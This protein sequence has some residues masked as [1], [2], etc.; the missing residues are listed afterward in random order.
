[1]SD[2]MK[3]LY[4]NYIKPYLDTI[5]QGEYKSDF[6]LLEDEIV[7]A[8]ADSFSKAQEFTATHAFL[9]GLRTGQGLSDSF[10]TGGR[11]DT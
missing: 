8:I 10:R 4:A 3:W 7:S 9:L 5:P 11:A 6:Y 2:F 1:M